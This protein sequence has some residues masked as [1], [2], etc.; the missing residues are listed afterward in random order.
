MISLKEWTAAALFAATLLGPQAAFAD[1]LGAQAIA[2]RDWQTAEEQILAG[3]EQNPGDVFRLLNLAAVYGQTDRKEEAAAIY[4][5]I[6]ESDS[7]RVAALSTGRER[8]VQAVAE[9]GLEI[10]TEAE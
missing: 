7:D 5:Q 4:Q 1:D 10:L 6:L 3:L 2:E 8:P 9:R